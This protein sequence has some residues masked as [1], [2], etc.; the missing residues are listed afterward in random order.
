MSRAIQSYIQAGL[1]LAQAATL[2][3]INLGEAPPDSAR[4]EPRV[5]GLMSPDK[6][7]DLVVVGGAIPGN[8]A[9]LG[10]PGEARVYERLMIQHKV[11]EKVVGEHGTTQS[12]E[13][14]KT[15][16][17]ANGQANGQGSIEYASR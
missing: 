10:K 12:C 4:G 17:Q 13:L 16:G 6:V 2:L 8:A 7:G 11:G 14:C 1:S 3:G 9:T 5:E 15:R